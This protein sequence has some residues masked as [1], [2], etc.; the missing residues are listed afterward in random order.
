M[1]PGRGMALFQ[2]SREMNGWNRW[3]MAICL[4]VGSLAYGGTTKAG[5]TG[6]PNIPVSKLNMPPEA[7][8]S[9][10]ELGFSNTETVS[11][12]DLQAQLDKRSRMLKLHQILGLITGVPLFAEYLIGGNTAGKVDEGSK[13]TALHAGLG[14]ATFTLYATTAGFAIMAPKPD[15]VKDSGSTGIHRYLAW[16]HGPLM[17]ITPVLGAIINDKIQHGKDPGKLAD[18]HGAAASAL[19]V[20]YGAAMSIMVLNF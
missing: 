14:I 13:N 5:G 1:Y 16:I 3:V 19:L 12:P 15:G 20:S 4:V 18:I 7:E 6:G 9:L 8:P 10:D 11:N 2:G 17:I